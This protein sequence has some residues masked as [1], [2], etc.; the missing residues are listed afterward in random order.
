MVHAMSIDV[1]DFKSAYLRLCT[2][3][4]VDAQ[5]SVLRKIVQ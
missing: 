1:D 5:D 4:G 2:E 3:Q